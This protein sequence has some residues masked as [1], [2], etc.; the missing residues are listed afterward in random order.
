MTDAAP[1]PARPPGRPPGEVLRGM[2][3]AIGRAAASLIRRAY[4]LA[5]IVVVLGLSWRALRYLVVSLIFAAPPPP[6]ITQLP[7]RLG[8]DVLRTRQREF[9][10]VVAT[11]HARSPLAHY[12]RLDG[13]FQ[14]DRFND[15]T[16]SGCH[17]PLPH[18]QRK[19]V[20][21]FLNMHATSM[22][23]GV[24]HMQGDETPL[25]LTWYELENGQACGPP[26]LLRAYARVDALAAHPAGE[27]TRAQQGDLVAL[28]RAAT[29]VA[30]DEPS[31]AGLTEHFAAVRAGSE[32]FLRLLDVARHTLPRFFRGEYGAKLARRGADGPPHLAHPHT[33]A[34][35][36]QYLAQGGGLSREERERLL[37]E[38]H[39]LRREKSRTCAECHSA[40]GSLIDFA[41]LGY[42]LRRV[43]DLQKNPVVQQV[44]RIESGEPF[45]LPGVLG[46]DAPPGP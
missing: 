19:E 39:P 21:A 44:M 12:H 24:C 36:R 35:V 30:N 38:V 22:H 3:R 5:L 25:P 8:G 16:R 37:A 15:C 7:T 29:R 28:L 1:K 32:E 18:A 13:W 34:A 10:G 45:Y 40:E 27:L 31:L 42:P 17:A 26:P 6:Q 23:C 14:P 41:A 4:A 33:A 46:G 11:E 9:A 43:R 20:R 2:L